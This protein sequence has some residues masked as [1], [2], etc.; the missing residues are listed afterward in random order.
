MIKSLGPSSNISIIWPSDE[1]PAIEIVNTIKSEASIHFIHEI[2]LR[3]IIPEFVYDVYSFDRGIASCQDPAIRSKVQR[4]Q[5]RKNSRVIIVAY[6]CGSFRRT[7]LLRDNVRQKFASATQYPIFDLM[8]AAETKREKAHLWRIIASPATFNSYSVRETISQ[9][10]IVKLQKLKEWSIQQNIH[11]NDICIVGGAVLDLYGYKRCDDVDIIVSNSH[12]NR[13]GHVPANLTNNIDLVRTGYARKINKPE[14]YSDDELIYGG[15]KHVVARGIKFAKLD[16]VL[17]RKKFS[18]RPKDLM[19]LERYTLSRALFQSQQLPETKPPID[20]LFHDR[21]DLIVKYLLFKEFETPTP[22]K[23]ILEMYKDMIFKRTNGYE[24]FDEFIPNQIKKTSIDDYIIQ[25]HGLYKSM[26]SH[27]FDPNFPIPYY[28]NGIQNGSHR[29]AC[30]LALGIHV[31]AIKT[32]PLKF[33]TWGREWFRSHG[34][35]K[36]HIKYLKTIYTQLTQPTFM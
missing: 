18:A 29:I 5:D 16:I 19:D 23:K 4:L 30:A 6:R 11:L 32:K 13:F 24:A 8:H 27:G 25:A 12:R 34:F 1:V 7:V 35:S 2:D 15:N 10:L 17:E 36:T 22:N 26:K 28:N 31:I 14:C 20:L 21:L 33:N 3:H 9:N